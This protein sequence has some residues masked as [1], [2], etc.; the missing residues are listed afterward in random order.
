ML[1]EFG[2]EAV[3]LVKI[4]VEGNESEVLR[5]ASVTLARSDAVVMVEVSQKHIDDPKRESLAAELKCLELV[6]YVAFWMES[7]SLRETPHLN[8]EVTLTQ[9]VKPR[10]GVSTINYFLVKRMGKHYALIPQL[11]HKLRVLK[12]QKHPSN[13][14]AKATEV[15]LLQDKLWAK[16][17]EQEVSA[18]VCNKFFK[19]MA[20]ISHDKAKLEQTLAVYAEKLNDR[21][22]TNAKLKTMLVEAH[23]QINH[24]NSGILGVLCRIIARINK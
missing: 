7:P 6:G 4:D 20:K 3:D 13:Q 12:R 17:V 22:E 14:Q 19:E 10:D 11:F 8:S 9:L 1:G 18:M 21:T 5:G 23:R 15:E 16:S 24:M 2:I